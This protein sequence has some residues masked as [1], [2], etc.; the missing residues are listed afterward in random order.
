MNTGSLTT[1]RPIPEILCRTEGSLERESRMFESSYIGTD[2]YGRKLLWPGMVV[3]INTATGK[4]VPYS[5]AASYGTG[6]NAPVGLVRGIY[7][8]AL[9]ALP[10]APY[11]AGLFN[12]QFCYIFGSAVG[13]I[14]NAVKTHAN[15]T[16]CKWV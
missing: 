7:D 3:A 11:Y 15:M 12:E 2:V 4:Y 1:L 9:G 14:T 6:S 10:I 8:F 13:T 5:A 16:M